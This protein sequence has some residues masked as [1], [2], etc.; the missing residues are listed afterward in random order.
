MNERKLLGIE[1]EGKRV[2]GADLKYHAYLISWRTALPRE[3]VLGNMREFYKGLKN[4]IGNDYRTIEKLYKGVFLFGEKEDWKVPLGEFLDGDRFKEYL[5]KD[6]LAVRINTEYADMNYNHGEAKKRRKKL[7]TL[8]RDDSI[9][10]ISRPAQEGI[11][12]AAPS[13]ISVISHLDLTPHVAELI[14]KTHEFGICS[15]SLPE[16]KVKLSNVLQKYG[17]R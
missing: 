15:D 2:A 6:V 13:N 11:I 1:I 3:E 7:N 9:L 16:L 10:L 4:S 14:Q 17:L 12:E 8:S 5:S